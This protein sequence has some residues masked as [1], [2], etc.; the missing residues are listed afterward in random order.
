SSVSSPFESSSGRAV[1]RS[2][3]TQAINRAPAGSFPFSTSAWILMRPLLYPSVTR[4]P[5]I[6]AFPT[7]IKN[8]STLGKTLCRNAARVLRVFNARERE[9]FGNVFALRD[10]D[11]VM[12]GR[13]IIETESTLGVC[14]AGSNRLLDGIVVPGM[15]G[16][17]HAG[18]ENSLNRDAAGD[19]AGLAL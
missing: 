12:T 16:N 19:R 15:Q 13:N 4:N 11:P 1:P 17:R 10:L 3:L 2:P 18:R 14:R 7:V 5:V 8:R 6:P 9:V